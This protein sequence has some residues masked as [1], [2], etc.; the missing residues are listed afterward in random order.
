M[1]CPA[2]L[3]FFSL[4]WKEVWNPVETREKIWKTGFGSFDDVER[5]KKN[6]MSGICDGMLQIDHK[7]TDRKALCS[8]SI[9]LLNI[10]DRSKHRRANKMSSDQKAASSSLSATAPSFSLT[11]SQA[12]K[13]P[14]QKN[15]NGNSNK[16]SNNDGNLNN[17]NN[18]TGEKKNNNRRRRNGKNANANGNANTKPPPQDANQADTAPSSETTDG[19]GNKTTPNGGNKNQN[20]NNRK[21]RQRQRQRGKQKAANA[22]ANPNGDNNGRVSADNANT[23]DQKQPPASTAKRKNKK[24]KPKKKYPWRKH[25]PEGAVDPI[26][27]EDLVSLDY[28]PFALCV[29]E[30]YLPVPIWPVP[31]ETT[32]DNQK[33]IDDSND[34]KASLV[35]SEDMNR[36]RLADQWGEHMLPSKPSNNN[37][38][39]EK[40]TSPPPPP[41]SERPLNLFDG[42]ALAFYMVS[43][44]QFID[45]FTRRDLTRAELQNLDNYL[46]KYGS[47]GL[48]PQ[49]NNNQRN[50]KNKKQQKLKVVDAYDAKG[51]TLSSA[52]AAAAT[53]QGR[54]DIMQQT[55]QQLLNT[56]F[57]GQPSVSSIPTTNDRESMSRRQ[58]A[59][60]FSLQEQY[61]AMQRQEREAVRNR[62]RIYQDAI[63]GFGPSQGSEEEFGGFMIIDDD[64]N[65]ELR[66]RGHNDFP[67]L[68]TPVP[69]QGPS[70]GRGGTTPFVSHWSSADQQRSSTGAFPALPKTQQAEPSSAAST[71][72]ASKPKPKPKPKP[73]KSLAKMFK[74]V[75]KTTAKEKQNQWEAREA[76]RRK[77]MMSNLTY[78]MNPVANME[79]TST[80]LKAPPSSAAGS[81]TEEQLERNRAFAEALGVKP[82]TQRH[83]ATG[84]AR[85]TSGEELPNELEA[86][87]YPDE[88]IQSARDRSSEFLLKLE[89]RWKRF[90]NDD[91]AASLPLN[92]MDRNSRKFVHHYAEFWHLKTESF[93]P[94]PNRYIHCVKLHD[95][96]MPQPLLSD[97]ARHWR[98][99]SLPDATRTI[100]SVMNDHTVQQT[101]GQTS[102]SS[103][104][105]VTATP[106][107]RS[108]LA[109]SSSK[110]D[111]VALG[112]AAVQNSRSDALMDKQRPQLKLLP[113]TVPRELPPYEEQLEQEAQESLALEE[114]LCRRQVRM[115][116]KRRKER[117]IE[118]KKRQ[119]LEDAFASDDESDRKPAAAGFSDSDSEWSNDQEAPVFDGS[120]EE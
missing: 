24:R 36:Q 50:K 17:A 43:Q 87:L 60:R 75:K 44:L 20:N 90:L 67:S 82:A 97:V 16:L 68:A 53:A 10:I 106:K 117:E 69:Q 58:Q 111:L 101:A 42:R 108:A 32:P 23:A 62:E 26:T 2:S 120:D 119:A 104:E 115:E 71:T 116:E 54:A 109:M 33:K 7:L 3:N 100:A 14:S 73:S 91:K 11:P 65:P 96:R 80:L 86:V 4:A 92:R 27:L 113:R 30:P 1:V 25:I 66:G 72:T 83:Y 47:A 102:T 55:A 98:G 31:K 35:D 52:G 8:Q 12:L 88:L 81:A 51:I 40:K 74:V 37:N 64:E 103:F 28:P 56:L 99:P 6:E 112:E 85:P 39:D 79:P 21:Q 114:D 94:E 29:D 63:G 9:P 38:T 78:G 19:K 46:D 93:D 118:Q 34:T 48:D 49:T 41:L 61:T 77:A 15:A 5:K 70:I 76:A 95:T 84:W 59:E 107:I 57:V 110:G 22:A 18:A 45:P 89:K 105:T 13:K